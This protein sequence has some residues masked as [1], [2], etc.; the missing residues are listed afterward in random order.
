MVRSG[1]TLS[2]AGTVLRW[3]HVPYCSMLLLAMPGTAARVGLCPY[4]RCLVLTTGYGRAPKP[5]TTSARLG[6]C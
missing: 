2:E 5:N 1:P 6:A 4:Q 3:Y